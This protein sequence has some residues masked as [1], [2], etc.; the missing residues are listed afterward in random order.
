MEDNGERKEDGSEYWETQKVLIETTK[1]NQNKR[2]R[3]HYSLHRFVID[4]TK[5]PSKIHNKCCSPVGGNLVRP[6]FVVHTKLQYSTT[7]L[8][9]FVIPNYLLV[10]RTIVFNTVLMLIS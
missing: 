5:L 8:Y 6:D 3:L 9:S 2:P 4:P 10:L 1:K 7:I